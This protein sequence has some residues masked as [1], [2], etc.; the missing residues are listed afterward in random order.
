M[1]QLLRRM[2]IIQRAD[3]LYSCTSED[4]ESLRQKYNKLTLTKTNKL[5]LV[6]N[7]DGG[8]TERDLNLVCGNGSRGISEAMRTDGTITS[9]RR[10]IEQIFHD[11]FQQQFASTEQPDADT[12]EQ[13]ISLLC[14]K[15]QVMEQE[16]GLDMGSDVTT[17]ELR[18]ALRHMNPTEHSTRQ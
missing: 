16:N 18:N 9:D 17:D 12:A 11:Y 10:E 13:R 3:T 1:N 15:L 6:R 5:D 4:L 8:T 14:S 7:S 2:R